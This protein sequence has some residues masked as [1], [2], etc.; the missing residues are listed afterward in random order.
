MLS[1]GQTTYRIFFT[2]TATPDE[3]GT[4]TIKTS[5]S[6]G[7]AMPSFRIVNCPWKTKRHAIYH[8][9][10]GP[11]VTSIG[12]GAFKGCENLKIS[13]YLAQAGTMT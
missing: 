9:V 4:I 2:M 10:I 5:K 1:W 11:S 7:E 6:G 8:V 3:Y 13:K 12:E